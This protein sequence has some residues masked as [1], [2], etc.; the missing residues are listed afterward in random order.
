VLNFLPRGGKDERP[1]ATPP[2]AVLFLA[3]SFA[4]PG[5]AEHE[6]SPVTLAQAEK[7]H[8]A[9][10]TET[11]P[12]D[13]HAAHVAPPSPRAWFDISGLPPPRRVDDLGTH[14]YE[15]AVATWSRRTGTFRS[16]RPSARFC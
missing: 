3:L 7:P 10:K 9:Q 13:P 16:T 14:H 1:H 15:I 11:K 6:P 12:F 8:L 5:L 4:G 2:S